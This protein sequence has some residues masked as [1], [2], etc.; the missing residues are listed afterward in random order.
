MF[1][2]STLP[3]LALIGLAFCLRGRW[4]WA[5]FGALLSLQDAAL[6]T[7]PAPFGAAWA[8][9]F[10]LLIAATPLWPGRVL[11]E[12]ATTSGAALIGILLANLV[13]I[14]AVLT[15]FNGQFVVMPNFALFEPSR[16]VYSDFY[17][18]HVNQ[19]IYLVLGIGATL[20]LLAFGR[21]KGWT[22]LFERLE[23][24]LIG[25]VLFGAGLA[26][27]EWISANQGLWFPKE[28]LHYDLSST[29]WKQKIAGAVRISGP[30]SEPSELAAQLGVAAAILAARGAEPRLAGLR[31]GAVLAACVALLIST[32]TTGYVMLAAVAACYLASAF[33]T[34]LILARHGAPAWRRLGDSARVLAVSAVGLLAGMALLQYLIAEHDFYQVLIETLF[35]KT[36]S[37]SY[38]NREFSNELAR[39]VIVDSHL[40]GIGL[41]GHVA[42]AGALN[43]LA[44]LGA[45]GGAIIFGGF[46]LGVASPIFLKPDAI[47][48]TLRETT[49]SAR[50][51]TAAGC[52][53]LCAALM[54]SLANI[55]FQLFWIV[56]ACALTST[57]PMRSAAA[58]RRT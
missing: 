52:L 12:L 42:S 54:L 32:S 11:R 57:Y 43:I 49:V 30:F 38:H 16:A 34:P 29:A 17:K 7:S 24:A 47:D 36:R 51:A 26:L 8:A 6:I 39:R 5:A 37:M 18:P 19:M 58:D 50:V 13:A 20:W 46:A 15:V 3:A 4:R 27:W 55:N 33:A 35:H 48:Q 23:T 31:G 10:G 22:A 14:L 45:A 28:W 40:I 25:F 21:Q 44:S 41:G 9:F 56:F 2:S 1:T 53:A